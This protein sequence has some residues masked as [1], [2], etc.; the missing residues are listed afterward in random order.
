MKHELDVTAVI[1][2]DAAA[3]WSTWTDIDRFPAWDPREQRNRLDGPFA[4]GATGWS[5][6]KGAPGGP[7]TICRIEP[8]RS[9]QATSPLPGGALTIDHRVEDLNDGR[10]RVSKRYV[11]T[12][13]M[14]LAFRCWFGPSIRRAMPASF[15]A[16]EAETAR[17]LAT[18]SA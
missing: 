11:A 16:L 17:R 14:S 7:Y 18:M 13:P 8:G 5:K 9:W 4:V 3:V 12:G 15:T 2:A 1:R 6:Q 10:V